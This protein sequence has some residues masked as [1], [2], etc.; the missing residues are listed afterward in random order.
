MFDGRLAGLFGQCPVGQV[1]SQCVEYR[2][3]LGCGMTPEGLQH[4]VGVVA[5]QELFTQEVGLV[6]NLRQD[7]D[8]YCRGDEATDPTLGLAASQVLVVE[9][10]QT[11]EAL[12]D[13]PGTIAVFGWG[14]NSIAVA[15]FPWVQNARSVIYWG[16]LDPEGFDILARFRAECPCESLLM[17]HDSVERWRDFAVPHA[18]DGSVDVARLTEH[19]RAAL[20][21]LRRDGLRLEQERIPMGAAV[22]LL[23]LAD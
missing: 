19:E 17:D 21:V 8:H 23:M 14:D 7:I 13:V 2:R 1:S 12:P 18:A 20:D 3:G 11:L 4:V 16:D 6:D 15:R 9:N 22:E 5:V 10:L